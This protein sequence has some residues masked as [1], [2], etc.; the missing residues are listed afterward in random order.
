MERRAITERCVIIE[1]RAV[2]EQCAI[3]E[4]RVMMDARDAALA[5]T[6][7]KYS[8]SDAAERCS[9]G[10]TTGDAM[11]AT[12]CSSSVGRAQRKMMER[13]VMMDARDA[14][15]ATTAHKYS[16]SDAAE[17]C[18]VGRTTGDAMLATVC[19]SSIGRA[20]R[21]M[22]EW[23]VMIER[24]FKYQRGGCIMDALVRIA[25]V[26][27]AVSALSGCDIWNNKTIALLPTRVFESC[28]EYAVVSDPHLF[29]HTDPSYNSE[30][31][32][33]SRRGVIF[34][35]VDKNINQE[36]IYS[37][38]GYWYA[39]AHQGVRGW[40][41]GTQLNIYCHRYQAELRQ[42]SLL[43]HAR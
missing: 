18:S 2:M 9:V 39:I 34:E 17:R 15:L 20:Q 6:A 22:M 37:E 35:I 41:F 14:A 26:L 1:R 30:I 3:T 36:E 38:Q 13:C 31:I 28:E 29:V 25:F 24:R 12:V 19:S 32:R 40:V 8:V 11:L 7:H 16:V 5:T 10:R 4:G 43:E 42:E 33:I 21:K 27:M 23:C